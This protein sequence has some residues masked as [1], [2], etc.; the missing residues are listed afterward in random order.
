[1]RTVNATPIPS[2]LRGGGVGSS[3]RAGESG[4]RYG[5]LRCAVQAA[6]IPGRRAKQRTRSS[7]GER[8]RDGSSLDDA[9]LL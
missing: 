3:S 2:V 4:S 9:L 8:P 7:K 5:R 1:M 6:T